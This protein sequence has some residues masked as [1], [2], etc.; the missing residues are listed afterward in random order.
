MFNRQ[1]K[2]K[3]IVKKLLIYKTVHSLSLTQQCQGLIPVNIT[4]FEKSSA[5]A[6]DNSSNFYETTSSFWDVIYFRFAPY[7]FKPWTQVSVI[8]WKTWWDNL[9]FS[10][11]Q[12][13]ITASNFADRKAGYII[14][15][16]IAP[17][18]SRIARLD[19]S[20]LTHYQV[21]KSLTC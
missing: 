18:V 4:C 13:R 6:E 12:C 21:R 2:K 3:I 5:I 1:I 11:R 20:H 9:E 8:T 15:W 19:F 10:T 14:K 16:K 7:S 17:Q